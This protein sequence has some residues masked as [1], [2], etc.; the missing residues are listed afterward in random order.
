MISKDR[1]IKTY[2]RILLSILSA[3]LLFLSFR[4]LGFFAW[5]ALIPFLFSITGADL[6][7]SI[8]LSFIC[9][10]G[11]FAGMTYWLLELYVKYT[12]PMI[13]TVLSL[14]FIV[15][16]IAAYFILNRIRG[17]YIRLVLITAVWI[18]IEFARSQTFLAFTIGIIGYSQ[19]SFLPLMQIT[20]FTGIYGVSFIILL[21]NMALYETI[22]SFSM[23][24]RIKNEL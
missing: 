18:L 10:L 5:F 24:N 14:Y 21:F 9:G 15:F 19:H 22:R 2:Q 1:G 6:K 23:K 20:R 8:S 13:I 11:F 16:G 4:E 17:S 7:R 3:T 12:W